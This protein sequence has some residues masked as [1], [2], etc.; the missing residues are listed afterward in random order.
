MEIKI[1]DL[2]TEHESN[3]IDIEENKVL[4]VEIELYRKEIIEFYR[5]KMIHNSTKRL[6]KSFSME[7]LYNN[8]KKYDIQFADLCWKA[9]L[10][11]EIFYSILENPINY[12][13]IRR[14]SSFEW[15]RMIINDI[16][17]F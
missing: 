8:L 1:N 9:K 6:W 4:K 13:N 15:I 5:D 17:Y 14:H 7:E 3:K 16:K 11:G 12:N 2:Q 10:N